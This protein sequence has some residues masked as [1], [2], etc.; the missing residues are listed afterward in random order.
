MV[1]WTRSR[2]RLWEI[3]SV[4]RLMLLLLLAEGGLLN[5]FGNGFEWMSC[6][7][8]VVANGA[9]A[10]CVGFWFNL[11]LVLSAP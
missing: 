8:R 2:A 9:A 11:G 7:Q 6:K 10:V 1:S 4:L 5:L 3:G